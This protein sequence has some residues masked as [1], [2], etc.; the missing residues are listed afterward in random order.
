MAVELFGGEV[1]A[2]AGIACVFS[3]L[4]SGQQGIYRSQ[5]M[6]AEKF[7]QTRM[8]A[9]PEAIEAKLETQIPSGDDRG[10]RAGYVRK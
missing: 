1:G 9:V 6:G 4:V 10:S 3:Y 8:T 5:R 7:G 2:Y